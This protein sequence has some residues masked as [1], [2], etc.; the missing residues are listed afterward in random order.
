MRWV[1]SSEQDIFFINFNRREGEFSETESAEAS[2]QS[3]KKRL[4]KELCWEK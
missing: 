2:R 3:L 4:I 1:N